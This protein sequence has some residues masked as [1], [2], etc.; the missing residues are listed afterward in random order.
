MIA[1]SRS[2]PED[3]Q[4][5]GVVLG[6]VAEEVGTAVVAA[7]RSA[8]VRWKG[9][10]GHDYQ[11]QLADVASRLVA[12]ER[13]YDEACDVL[14][15]YSRALAEARDLARHADT[16]VA[17]AVFEQGPPRAHLLREQAVSLEAV[18]AR[19]AA[20]ALRNLTDD[21]PRPR[22]GAATSRFVVEAAHGFAGAVTGTVGLLVSAVEGLP[23]LG[24]HHSRSKAR[25]ELVQDAAATAQ[26][27]LAVEEFLSELRAH[28]AGLATG[29]LAGALVLRKTHLGSRQGRL[30]G[31][32]DELPEP[33]L[34]AVLTGTR[35]DASLEREWVLERAQKRF[36]AEIERLKAVPPQT[37]EAM[38]TQ[39]VDLMHAE[40]L[41]GHTIYKHV[42]RDVDFLA[43]RRKTDVRQ[44]EP[45]PEVSSFADLPEAERL[46]QQV[47][48]ANAA[49][50]AAFVNG[51]AERLR[52]SAAAPPT[53]GVV[54]R[55][56]G[57]EAPRRVVVEFRRRDGGGIYVSTA[58]LR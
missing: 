10:A 41:G 35:A 11:H 7:R 31:Y 9:M 14:L 24:S 49:E 51:H 36:Y 52:V 5:C 18:A 56:L 6:Q 12:I 21:A 44:G 48:A 45:L 38:L 26:P 2:R 47:V 13:A 15:S 40:A 25:H 27:W 33:V 43:R 30:F 55:A 42:G 32:V 22:A 16:L 4:R 20:V 3:L 34:R 54:V 17:E 8:A 57:P 19:R 50:V 39:G 1:L 29:Q 53:S 23:F 46:V 37:L 28:H 58:F